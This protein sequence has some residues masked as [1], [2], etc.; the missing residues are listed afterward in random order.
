MKKIRLTKLTKDETGK[1]RGG[2]TI[3]NAVEQVP[4]FASNG[5]C[6]GGGWGD[7]NTNCTGTCSKCSVNISTGEPV[8]TVTK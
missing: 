1:L 6:Q 3:Q 7:T 8:K 4:I 2:F 5:N